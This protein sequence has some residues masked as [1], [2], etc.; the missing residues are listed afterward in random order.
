MSKE[1]GQLIQLEDPEF[2]QL[3]VV[4]GHD[5]VEARYILS[6]SLMAR[7][8]DFRKKASREVYVSFI[9]DLIYVAIQYEEDLFEPRLFKSMLNFGPIQKYFEN[10]QLMIGI[11]EDLKL[12]RRIWSRS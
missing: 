5:Q 2:N 12:N 9:D 7:L 1:R 10:L 6:T 11:V 4:Y 3:F 8:V